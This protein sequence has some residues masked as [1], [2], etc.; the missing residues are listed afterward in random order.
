MNNVPTAYLANDTL[1]AHSQ[2]VRELLE[3]KRLP[4]SFPRHPSFGDDEVEAYLLQSNLSPLL[5]GKTDWEIFSVDRYTAA[6]RQQ[7]INLT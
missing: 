2:W 1:L 3:T 7:F 6:L 4:K 5:N